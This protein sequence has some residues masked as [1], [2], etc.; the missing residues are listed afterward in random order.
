[1][2][3]ITFFCDRCKEPIATQRMPMGNYEEKWLYPVGSREWC[4]ECLDK[5]SV[6]DKTNLEDRVDVNDTEF[7]HGI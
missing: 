6:F 7:E 5:L 3:K 4:R 1:M 2:R